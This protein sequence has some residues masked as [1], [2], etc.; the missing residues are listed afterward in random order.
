MG[1]T[2]TLMI[3]ANDAD[4]IITYVDLTSFPATADL[5]DPSDA[6][7][8]GPYYASPTGVVGE[9]QFIFTPTI[10]DVGSLSFT[11]NA[12]DNSGNSC[13]LPRG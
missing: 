5:L 9:Y 1:D 8:D 4:G 3:T 13:I 7:Y 6:D 12:I 11:A 2:V 10:Q